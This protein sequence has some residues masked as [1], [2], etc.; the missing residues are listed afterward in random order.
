MLKIDIVICTYNRPKKVIELVGQLKGFSKEFNSIILIDSS[1]SIHPI[2]SSDHQIVYLRSPHKNQP[3]QR[4]LGYTHSKADILL[5][6]DDDMELSNDRFISIIQHG[7]KDNTVAGIAINFEDKHT[8]TAL[9][10]IPR[11]V[12]FSGM[13]GLKKVI[14]WLSGYPVLPVG[15]LGLCGIRGKQPVQGG[16]TEWLSGGAFAAR[17]TALF[18]N[19][20]FQL[21]DLFEQKLGMGEDAMI[22]YSLSKQGVLWYHPELLFYHNDQRDSAY[23]VDH[24]AYSRRVIFSRLYLSL[25]RARLN[26]GSYLIAVLHYHWY[27][28]WRVAGL[29][30]NWFIGRNTVKYNLLMGAI[31][32]WKLAG[33]F[34]FDKQL[35]SVNKWQ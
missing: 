29:F 27:V 18:Q 32:G 3:Y 6:L 24:F 19:F 21:F 10:A 30:I 20:N 35:Q 28:L 11:S 23:S 34:K 13:A 16:K 15:K 2:L 12:L 5:F 8:D 4:Y 1:D 14:G 7:F 17:R 26:G 22:G 9:A 31:A 25:E 33:K